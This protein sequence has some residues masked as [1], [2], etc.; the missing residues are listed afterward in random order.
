MYITVEDG[1]LVAQAS[2]QQKTRVLAQ[3][4]NYFF[5]EEADGSFEFL[6]NEWDI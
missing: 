6:K 2:G 4:E 3:K 5:A 1:R